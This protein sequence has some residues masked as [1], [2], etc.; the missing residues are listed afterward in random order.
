MDDKKFLSQEISKDNQIHDNTKKAFRL[1]SVIHH[2]EGGY[3]EN[4]FDIYVGEDG[5]VSISK[6]G[7]DDFI[8]LPPEYVKKL[9]ELLTN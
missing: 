7:G 6:N 5:H 4:D 3:T 8:Y 2:D 9:I 1:W